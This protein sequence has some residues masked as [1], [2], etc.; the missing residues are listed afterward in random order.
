MVLKLLLE[1]RVFVNIPKTETLNMLALIILPLSKQV[2]LQ[3][4]YIV[5]YINPVNANNANLPMI[6]LQV[7]NATVLLVQLLTVINTM[8]VMKNAFLAKLATF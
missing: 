5:I 4:P 3:R 2:L 1:I 8:I 6:F 7:E